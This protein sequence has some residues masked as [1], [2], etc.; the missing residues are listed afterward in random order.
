MPRPQPRMAAT[1]SAQQALQMTASLLAKVNAASAAHVTVMAV[2]AESVVSVGNALSA[3]LSA[4][5]S[6]PKAARKRWF[7]VNFLRKIRLSPR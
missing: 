6:Q 5:V 1:A 7:K 4:T 3:I 2:T